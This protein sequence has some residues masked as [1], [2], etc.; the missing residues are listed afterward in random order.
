MQRSQNTECSAYA[1]ISD[2]HN[3]ILTRS[4]D[5]LTILDV[6]FKGKRIDNLHINLSVTL[7]SLLYSLNDILTTL[8]VE[9]VPCT[10]HPGYTY[11]EESQTCVCYHDK[12]K[13]K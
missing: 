8:V 9:L 10:D 11:N 6:S 1:L 3:Y 13:C 4:I 12:V 2:N 5:N 7:T